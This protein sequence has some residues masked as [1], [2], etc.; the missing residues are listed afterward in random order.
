MPEEFGK[1]GGG[2][3]LGVVDGECLAAWGPAGEAVVLRVV[4]NLC[5]F[6]YE[7]GNFAL[8]ASLSLHIINCCELYSRLWLEKCGSGKVVSGY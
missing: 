5:E 7:G 1:E 4:E 8:P 3:E 2:E 6:E